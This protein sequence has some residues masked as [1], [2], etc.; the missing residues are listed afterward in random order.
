MGSSF[1]LAHL[2][3]LPAPPDLHPMAFDIRPASFRFIASLG[4]IQ[5][6]T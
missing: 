2:A 5:N 3:L 6:L 1:V 4:I